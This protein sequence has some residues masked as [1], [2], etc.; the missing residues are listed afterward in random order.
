LHVSTIEKAIIEAIKKAFEL[1]EIKL[2]DNE[3]KQIQKIVNEILNSEIS[4]N[5]IV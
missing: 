5:L 1:K 3:V 4:G 2:N